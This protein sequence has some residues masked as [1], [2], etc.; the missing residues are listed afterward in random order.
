MNLLQ[1]IHSTVDRGA[2]VPGVRHFVEA[3]YRREFVENRE[4][5]LFHGVFASFET[6]AVGASLYGASGYDNEASADLYLSHMRADAHDYPAMFWLAKSFTAGLRRVLDLGG[7]V[8][9]KYYAF[10]TSLP[11]PGD[12]DWT[13]VDVP[14]VVAKGQAL[15][16]ERRASPS[17]HFDVDMSSAEGADILF[18][19]GS[20]Q[21]LPLT[22]GAY[23]KDWK[24]RPSR[25]IINITPI[26]PNLGYFTVNSIGTAFC[27]YRIQTQAELVSELAGL[28]YTMKDTWANRGK[29]LHLPLHPELSLNHYRGFCFDFPGHR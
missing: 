27:P 1:R 10:R 22:L 7:S 20:L 13:V 5:N 21:Y 19:S 6:A 28:G 3:S 18:A 8:G 25:I 4:R 24:K 17:L 15:A 12:V 26:H 23:L 2:F 14:A 9:I 16:S 11:L 29:E